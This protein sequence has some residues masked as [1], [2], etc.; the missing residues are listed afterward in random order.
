[1]KKS[2]FWFDTT[3]VY[4]ENIGIG[5]LLG[6][7]D[8]FVRSQASLVPSNAYKYEV[9]DTASNPLCSI[10]M[11]KSDAISC[12]Y[13]N[14]VGTYRCYKY[15]RKSIIWLAIPSSGKGQTKYL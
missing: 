8:V 9:R 2:I 1:M 15:I 12:H 11:Q 13:F 6:M 10:E 14:V 4:F 7:Y 3:A 5:E